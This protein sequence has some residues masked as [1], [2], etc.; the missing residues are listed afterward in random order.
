MQ[1]TAF[2]EVGSTGTCTKEIEEALLDGRTDLAVPN[3][4][5]LL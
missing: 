4:K 2:A 5:D 3:L 1:G